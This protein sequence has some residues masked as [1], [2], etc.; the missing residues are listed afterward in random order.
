M[1]ICSVD[2]HL[3]DVQNIKDSSLSE[4]KQSGVKYSTIR[5]STYVL[6]TIR[7]HNQNYKVWSKFHRISVN[8][9]HYQTLYVSKNELTPALINAQ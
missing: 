9:S 2:F 4:N 1:F 6:Y 7:I 3:L 8:L 5:C